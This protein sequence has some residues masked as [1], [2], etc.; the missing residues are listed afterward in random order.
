MPNVLIIAFMLIMVL[1]TVCTITYYDVDNQQTAIR[2]LALVLIIPSVA[3]LA[4]LDLMTP[5]GTAVLFGIIIGTALTG[6]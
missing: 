3:I 2:I 4:L 6:R 5:E 1:G